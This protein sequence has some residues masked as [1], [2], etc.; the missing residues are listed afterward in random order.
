MFFMLEGRVDIEIS[1]G[2]KSFLGRC[3]EALKAGIVYT[4][5]IINPTYGLI[6]TGLA[7][8]DKLIRAYN[9][10]RHYSSYRNSN[11]TVA[12]AYGYRSVTDVL[13]AIGYLLVP[14]PLAIANLGYGSMELYKNERF[15]PGYD[16][17]KEHETP[18][19]EPTK[20]PEK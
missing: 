1:D 12:D 2:T 10:L 15:S 11:H 5:R 19:D 4:A 3:F 17:I 16:I 14:A 7:V 18:K 9:G 20:K 8:A 6:A 13:G